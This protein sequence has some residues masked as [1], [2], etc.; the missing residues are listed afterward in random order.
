LAQCTIRRRLKVAILNSVHSS[1]S[2]KTARSDAGGPTSD[3]EPR[4]ARSPWLGLIIALAVGNALAHGLITLFF[5]RLNELGWY[6]GLGAINAAGILAGWWATRRTPDAAFTSWFG[7]LLGAVAAAHVLNIWIQTTWTSGGQMV[8]GNTLDPDAHLYFCYGRQLLG[9]PATL[10]SGCSYGNERYPW[11]EYPQGALALFAGTVFLAGDRALTFRWVFPLVML[12]FTLGTAWL[13]LALGRAHGA[14]RAAVF[15]TVAAV[16]SPYVFRLAPV[17]YDIAPAFF[18]VL[19]TYCFTVSAKDQPGRLWAVVMSG[20]AL[21]AGVLM[22]WLPGLLLPFVVGYYAQ[23]RAWREAGAIVL[24]AGG[25]LVVTLVPF[26]LW[27]PAKF[28]NPYKFHMARPLI[29]ESLWFVV[30]NLLLDPHHTAPS[31]PWGT[32]PVVLVS[33]RFATLVQ[34]LLTLVPLVLALLRKRTRAQWAALGLSSVAIFT[35]TNR[36]FSPQYVIMLGVIWAAALV[37]LCHGPRALTLATLALLAVGLANFLVYPLWLPGWV[38]YSGLMF[39]AAGL[40]TGGTI[41]VAIRQGSA[42]RLPAGS[43]R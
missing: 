7:P 39:S 6:V 15:L 36:I 2:T 17:R 8:F 4:L 22:K 27:D 34:V 23:R 13:L 21:A 9:W 5:P 35:L 20:A 42:A 18:L 3:S 37:P 28:L 40:L 30:Q 16:L 29:G 24:A 14:A 19:A 31:R 25:V 12:A 11:M 33:N 41:L 38:W 43:G 26:L 10:L 32:P 1:A